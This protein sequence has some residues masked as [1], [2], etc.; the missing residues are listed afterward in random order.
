MSQSYTELD[1]QL[2]RDWGKTE[3]I[4][5][6]PTYSEELQHRVRERVD[7]AETEREARVKV[8]LQNKKELRRQV[9]RIKETIAKILD[10]DTSLAEKLRILFREQGIT[11]AAIFTAIGMII[12]TIA[13]SITGGSEEGRA[14]PPNGLTTN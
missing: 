11:I 13:V 14:A 9:S 2:D 8:L 3:E 7:N 1:K 4:K 12:S 10:S 5:D 6:D